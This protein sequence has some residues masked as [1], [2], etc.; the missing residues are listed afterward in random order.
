MGVVAT[1]R[2][3]RV[4]ELNEAALEEAL[5]HIPAPDP[6]RML[7]LAE[8]HKRTLQRHGL[9]VRTFR[10][11]CHACTCCDIAPFIDV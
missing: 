7:R 4:N 3:L 2:P 11:M 9:D 6:D 5:G 10:T 1:L 8:E